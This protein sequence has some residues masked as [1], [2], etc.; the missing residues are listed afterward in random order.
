MCPSVVENFGFD[1][2]SNMNVINI[3]WGNQVTGAYYNTIL[4]RLNYL[5]YNL[6]TDHSAKRPL[7]G[8]T[9]TITMFP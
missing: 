4:N 6:D 7:N 3:F 5:H 9:C 8:G 2:L 1:L